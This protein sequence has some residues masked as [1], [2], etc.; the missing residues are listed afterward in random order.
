MAVPVDGQKPTV[1]L[2]LFEGVNQLLAKVLH[3]LLTSLNWVGH[4]HTDLVRAFCLSALLLSLTMPSTGVH[5]L[6]E[7]LRRT[8]Y[9]V[10]LAIPPEQFREI[11]HPGRQHPAGQRGFTQADCAHHI[12]SA[13]VLPCSA[14]HVALFRAA[15]SVFKALRPPHNGIGSVPPLH[16][17][18]NG[19]PIPAKWRNGPQ[20]WPHSGKILRKCLRLPRCTLSCWA[21][22]HSVD[23]PYVLQVHR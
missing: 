11:V 14:G 21:L 20:R 1:A 7:L 5:Y 22:R 15:T 9:V 3:G 8:S 13:D 2:P 4:P 12:S 6:V 23:F 18:C 10:H 16:V 17:L 19:C